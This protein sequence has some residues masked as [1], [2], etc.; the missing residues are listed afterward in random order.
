M[1]R[2][3]RGAGRS[4][5]LWHDTGRDDR[6]AGLVETIAPGARGRGL[7]GGT[8]SQP[9]PRDTSSAAPPRSD[10]T[11]FAQ[12]S[13]RWPTPIAAHPR[14]ACARSKVAEARRVPLGGEP[15]LLA[16]AGQRLRGRRRGVGVRRR[17]AAPQRSPDLT[18]ACSQRLHRSGGAGCER[19]PPTNPRRLADQTAMPT[20]KPLASSEQ[21][22]ENDEPT[23]PAPTRARH[24]A[25]PAARSPATA[26]QPHSA[27]SSP[28]TAAPHADPPTRSPSRSPRAP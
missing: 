7:V 4:A 28:P 26:G 23:T 8:R 3:C 12:G 22:N 1:R 17:R 15:L 5:T 11:H 24:H 14:A 10:G 21:P 9:A 6:A 18:E 25:P 2:E 19:V 13:A 16:P 27:S 20:E